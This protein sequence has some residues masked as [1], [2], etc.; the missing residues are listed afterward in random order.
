MA[1]VLSW[2]AV[3]ATEQP[4]FVVGSQFSVHKVTPGIWP[5]EPSLR[6]IRHK[7]PGAVQSVS[8]AQYFMH[9]EIVPPVL[10]HKLPGTH[11][12]PMHDAP[13][14]TVPLGTHNRV[15]AT[16]PSIVHISP[17]AQP[18]CGFTSLQGVSMHG[19][20]LDA[21]EADDAEEAEFDA[22]PIPF[23][24]EPAP[25]A[26]P[27]PEDDFDDEELG[28]VQPESPPSPPPPEPNGVP[29]AH[30]ATAKMPSDVSAISTSHRFFI[31]L[32]R[33]CRRIPRKIEYENLT[34]AC[35]EFQ[36]QSSDFVNTTRCR[37]RPA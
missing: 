6:L 7:P 17:P 11:S 35:G 31:V 29:F 30:A 5:L 22:P 9:V 26:P 10:T 37:S 3:P 25:P 8:A 12:L 36:F 14:E 27:T 24:D 16:V 21:D 13:S 15:P 20:L 28:P 33:A 34:P 2:H 23:E 32:P 18:H 4:L 19:P 1:S